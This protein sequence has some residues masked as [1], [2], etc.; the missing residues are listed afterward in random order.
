LALSCHADWRQ[1]RQLSEVKRTSHFDRATAASDPKRASRWLSICTA[2]NAWTPLTRSPRSR[3]V[4]RS[5]DDRHLA[6]NHVGH[7]R[8]HA[9]I[10]ALQPMILDRHVLALDI[11]GFGEAFTECGRTGS[12]VSGRPSMNKRDHR[13]RRLLRA[14]R[15]RPCDSRAADRGYELPPSN[16]DGHLTHFHWDH[17]CCNL[18]K[19]ITPQSAGL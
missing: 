11:A 10:V 9:I 19:N 6:T 1:P 14:R 17:A 2:T 5:G 4:C 3:S 12:G 16:V 7:H 15:E 18:G 8:G 13:H